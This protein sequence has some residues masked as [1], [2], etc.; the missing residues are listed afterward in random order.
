MTF[1]RINRYLKNQV[2]SLKTSFFSRKKKD[3]IPLETVELLF[4][5]LSKEQLSSYLDAVDLVQE[6]AHKSSMPEFKRPPSPPRPQ[7]N[8]YQPTV[9]KTTSP[10]KNETEEVVIDLNLSNEID[11]EV[12]EQTPDL[13][14]E[15]EG[16]RLAETHNS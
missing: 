11:L 7:K 13:S 8:I 10:P 9:D 6:H 14:T 2:V 4:A 12:P 1:T 5:M 16:R 15:E 3:F